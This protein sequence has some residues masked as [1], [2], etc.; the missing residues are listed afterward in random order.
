MASKEQENF[1]DRKV[2]VLG[3]LSK[4]NE[5]Q[6]DEIEQL[7]KKQVR[8]LERERREKLWQS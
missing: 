6:L 1:F 7:L 4:I 2:K 3:M 8:D 5:R